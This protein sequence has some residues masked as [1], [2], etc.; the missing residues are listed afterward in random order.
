MEKQSK[1]F[2]FLN[3][4]KCFTDFWEREG[5]Q[6]RG[7]ERGGRKQRIQSGLCADSREPDSGLE[8]TNRETMTRAKTLTD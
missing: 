6:G 7:R 4:F 1:W 8:L 5:E 3:F 2:L